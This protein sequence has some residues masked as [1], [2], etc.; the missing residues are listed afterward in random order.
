[1][2]PRDSLRVPPSVD[3]DLYHEAL[4]RR[5]ANPA[6]RHRT[7]QIAMDG[8]AKI[9]QRFLS[10]LRERCARNEASPV[11]TLGV[12]AWIRY[13]SGVDEMGSAH[14]VIDPLSDQLV[15]IT[16][17]AKGRV[18]ELVHG[19]LA[20]RSVFTVDLAEN[21]V[22]VDALRDT[23]RRLL[24]SGIRHTVDHLLATA[25]EPDT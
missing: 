14:A 12:A 17:R 20:L 25:T 21:P 4:M 24:D 19:V 18:D 13:V 16:A 1:M 8:S 7:R 2:R 9:P 23:L 11:L 10:P 5:L 6:V 3:T 22:F 15:A